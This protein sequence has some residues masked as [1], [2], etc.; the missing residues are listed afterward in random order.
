MISGWVWVRSS[1]STVEPA[2]H[3]KTGLE[4]LESALTA[5]VPEQCHQLFQKP[6]NPWRWWAGWGLNMSWPHSR[7][8]APLT[9]AFKFL[10]CLS[11]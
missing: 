4:A 3:G 2:A 11:L 10:V 5:A 8:R 6:P 1:V 9:L 7:H